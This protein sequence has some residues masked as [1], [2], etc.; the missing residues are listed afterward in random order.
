MNINRFHL[1][2]LISTIFCYFVPFSVT[3]DSQ[4]HANEN[5]Q[6]V[7]I[8]NDT[9]KSSRLRLNQVSLTKPSSDIFVNNTNEKSKNKCTMHLSYYEEKFRLPRNALKAISIKESGRKDLSGKLSPW[10]WAVNVD[11]KSYYFHNKHDAIKFVMSESKLGRKS[12]DVGCAQINLKFHGKHFESIAHMLD[13]KH[14]IAYAAYFLRSKYEESKNWYAAIS[15]Y[16]SKTKSLGNKYANGVI[17]ILSK[18]SAE[19]S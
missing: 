19:A 11:G 15:N 7:K 8:K 17:D 16:H 10:P 2:V 12:I 6:V 9:Q 4:K 3:A 5:P 14:N 13:P 18:L 1:I